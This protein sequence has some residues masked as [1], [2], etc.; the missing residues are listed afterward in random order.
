[1]DTRFLTTFVGKCVFTAV[2]FIV[3]PI[4]HGGFTEASPAQEHSLFKALIILSIF[5]AAMVDFMVSRIGPIA[6]LLLLP[7]L[8]DP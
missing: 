8:T 2:F 5:V 3:S 1:M 6:P 4:L 7:Y